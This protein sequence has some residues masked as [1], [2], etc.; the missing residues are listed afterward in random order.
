MRLRTWALSESNEGAR[1]TVNRQ[2]L[3]GLLRRGCLATRPGLTISSDQTEEEG[4]P[5]VRLRFHVPLE[6]SNASLSIPVLVPIAFVGT[7]IIQIQ[8]IFYALVEEVIVW[9][10]K[11][12]PT[13]TLIRL[14]RHHNERRHPHSYSSNWQD[15]HSGF[16]LFIS[17]LRHD[18]T[19]FP[20]L[21]RFSG[22]LGDIEVAQARTPS[23]DISSNYVV[24]ITL[25][26]KQRMRLFVPRNVARLP[27]NLW[28]DY[29]ELQNEFS[30]A[31]L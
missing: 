1:S 10:A 24:A 26:N 9:L 21:G 23:D 16:R 6:N 11:I 4:V 5:C 18:E 14:S 2:Y 12:G 25:S 30:T 27:Q 29:L 13:H 15:L 28:L 22:D 31:L 3:D 7:D 17:S 20:G 8:Y 19:C